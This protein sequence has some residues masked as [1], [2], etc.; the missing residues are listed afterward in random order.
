MKKYAKYPPLPFFAG[1]KQIES[2]FRFNFVILELLSIW[3]ETKRSLKWKIKTVCYVLF[4]CNT[5]YWKINL[6]VHCFQFTSF[7]KMYEKIIR[8]LYYLT[9]RG[10]LCWM[11]NFTKDFLLD[12]ELSSENEYSRKRHFLPLTIFPENPAG[13]LTFLCSLCATDAPRSM[14][15]QFWNYPI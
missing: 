8:N 11:V 5:T 3:W 13:K 9:E 10:R 4:L 1:K 15:T 14:M 6:N 12:T 2:L 7:E